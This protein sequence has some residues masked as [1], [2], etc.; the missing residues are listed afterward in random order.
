MT[1][2]ELGEK[3]QERGKVEIMDLKHE[4]KLIELDAEYALNECKKRAE[5]RNLE[6]DYVISEFQN[7]FNRLAK[8]IQ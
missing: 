5:S 2:K 3:C 8:E 1:I 6:L 7:A 4:K